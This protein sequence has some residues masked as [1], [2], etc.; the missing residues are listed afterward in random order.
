MEKDTAII[1]DLNG[2]LFKN[3][4]L[5]K[6]T[7]K[8]VENLTKSRVS[9]YIC[10]NTR[11]EKLE[12]WTLEFNLEK[13]FKKIF[14]SKKMDLLKNNPQMYRN[15]LPE[16]KEQ[17]IYF[18]D[19]SIQNIYAAQSVGIN[20]ILYKSDLQLDTDFKLLGIYDDICR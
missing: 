5:D 12:Q 15:I 13:Y 1:W 17:K 18:I 14:S 3:L 4:T 10:T 2:V 6:R 19:D 8:I 7:F 16:I 20:C 11:I 9:Q